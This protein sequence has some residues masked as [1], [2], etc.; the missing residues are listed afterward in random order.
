[1]T[2]VVFDIPPSVPDLTKRM[3]QMIEENV[4]PAA[5]LWLQGLAKIWS[6]VPT[7]KNF[8]KQFGHFSEDRVA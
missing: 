8:M 4:E 6:V 5:K 3:A 2:L 7:K 1:M